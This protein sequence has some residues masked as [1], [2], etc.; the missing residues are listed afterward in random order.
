MIAVSDETL[1]R[2][3]RYSGM[4]EGI[5]FLLLLFIAMPL[6]YIFD[7]PG[8]VRYV[9]WAHGV[10]FVN[11]GLFALWVAHRMRW[12]FRRLFTAGMAALLPFGPF[13]F[14][15]SLQREMRYRSISS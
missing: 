6:K 8:M 1:L 4:V 10:L 5:S 14:D 9:G 11:Y 3:F 12:S 7:A 13:V 2:W 15:K